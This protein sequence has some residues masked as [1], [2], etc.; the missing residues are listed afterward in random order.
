M[1]RETLLSFLDDCIAFGDATAVVRKVGV[2]FTQWSYKDLSTLAYRISRELEQRDINKGDRIILWSQNGPEWLATFYGCMLRGAILVPMDVQSTPD[3]IRS[4]N[5]QVRPKLIVTGNGLKSGFDFQ[6]CVELA[7]F[8]ESA[9]KRSGEPFKPSN[10]QSDDLI[11][12][13]FTSGTTSEPKG[14]CLSH[15]NVLANLNPIE[16]EIAKYR[17]WER[18]VHPVRFLNLVPFSHVF[19][20]IMGIFIPVL[21]GG[22]IVLQESLNPSE[23]IETTKRNHVS[24]I[25]AVPRVLETLREKIKRDYASRNQTEKFERELEA[26]ESWNPLKRW[27][28]FRRIHRQFGLK[29]F[30]F[31]SGGATLP[32]EIETFWDHLGFAVIQGYGMTET[33][34]LISVNHPFGKSRGS[35][36]KVLPGQEVRLSD[37]GE[38]TVRGDNISRGY[39]NASEQAA[40]SNGDWLHTG[41]IAERDEKGNLFF[42]GRQ[43]DVIVTAAGLNVYP[44]DLEAALLKQ[45]EIRDAS[46]IG[47][48]GPKGPEPLAVIIPRNET[49]EIEQAIKSSNDILAP[50]QQIRRW[51]VWPEPDFPRTAT[52]KVVKRE[53]ARRIQSK[54]ASLTPGNCQ[55]Q[56]LAEVIGKVGGEINGE[57]SPS[58]NLTTDLKL[59]SIGRVELL[60]ALED[61]YQIELDDS[62]F[63]AA[64]TFGDVERL[65]RESQSDETKYYPYP[66]W[67]LGFPATWIRPLALYLLIFLPTAILGWPKIRGRENL[68]NVKGPVLFVSN[69]I[70]RVD[71]GLILFA[72]PLRFS[73]RLAI[74]MD[75]EMLRGWLR[76]SP[77]TGFFSRVLWQVVYVLVVTFFNVFSLP[78]AGGFRKS[79]A[80]AGEA[81]DRGYNVLVFPEGIRADHDQMNPFKSGI[82]ILAKDLDATI[83][84][85]RIKGLAD[86]KSRRKHFTT[87]GRIS[88][89]FGEPVHYHED[90]DAAGI[91][92]D[93]ENRVKSLGDHSFISKQ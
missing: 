17:K 80:Y 46:V 39:W 18:F 58:A 30:G 25:V 47:V 33:A 16:N 79:F 14:V 62:A 10:I 29:F 13:V 63:T 1:K 77:E 93:L 7:H 65:I 87:P 37:T 32:T 21:L 89:F 73:H 85:I 5:A 31:V 86:L 19:G 22:E 3:F 68:R 49:S 61:R 43:K 57:L 2:R 74:A 70:A 56:V 59:D 66:K 8:I 55:D 50:H 76:P 51:H 64:T 92:R 34:S 67:A 24:V 52:L 82:G 83:V 20:Q 72:L 35:I 28:R 69:H 71:Q 81:M 38:V 4:V 41:D 53:L 78:K 27:W 15:H 36:G 9:N 91:T 60:S 12:I 11:E 26:S 90:V 23:I 6:N 44:E 42:R 75:G 40:Q 84:P 48:D 54:P 45:P 88:V